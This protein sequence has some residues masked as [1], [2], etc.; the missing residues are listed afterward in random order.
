MKKTFDVYSILEKAKGLKALTAVFTLAVCFLFSTNLS[1][2]TY[3]LTAPDSGLYP[4][5]GTNVVATSASFLKDF[6]LNSTTNESAVEILKAEQEIILNS[7][8]NHTTQNQELH[9]EASYTF[10]DKA[11]TK[12]T[13]ETS[14]IESLAYAYGFLEAYPNRFPG[15]DFEAIGRLYAE[16]LQ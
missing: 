13:E 9:S 15:V 2:Q 14:V 6:N 16:K 1:A 7:M 3:Q 11:V 5:P 4:D 12:L 8:P 10:L